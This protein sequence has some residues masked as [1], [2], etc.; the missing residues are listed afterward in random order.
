MR[1]LACGQPIELHTLK[2]WP[3]GDIVPVCPVPLLLGA[4]DLKPKVAPIVVE[5]ATHIEPTWTSP[6]QTN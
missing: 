2:E 4:A 5:Y 6:E 3:D 1:C